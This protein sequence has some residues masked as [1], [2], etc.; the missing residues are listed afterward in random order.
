MKSIFRTFID[1]VHCS[2]IDHDSNINSENMDLK[3]FL[4]EIS[5][6]KDRFELFA[7]SIG[8]FCFK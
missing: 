4:D 7:R 6:K 5:T 8:I 1:V 3:C 2:K